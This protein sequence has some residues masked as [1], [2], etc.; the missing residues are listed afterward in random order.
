MNKLKWLIPVAL[1]LP[2]ICML[3]AALFGAYF[4]LN[5]TVS[6]A[7]LALAGGLVLLILLRTRQSQGPY[8]GSATIRGPFFL[9]EH[10]VQLRIV[11][12]AGR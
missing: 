9:R 2:G 6:A 7:V 5:Q 12:T 4:D 3:Y 1:I 8:V 11:D 10:L